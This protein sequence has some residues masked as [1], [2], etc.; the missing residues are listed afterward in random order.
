MTSACPAYCKSPNFLKILAV[1][2]LIF[3]AAT[4]LSGG[5]VIFG[6]TEIQLAMGDTVSFVVWFNFVSGFAYVLA[7]IG[8]LRRAKWGAY[9]AIAVAVAIAL[10]FAAF[11]LH[12][13]NDGAFEP[14]T[15]A[16]MVLRTGVWMLIACVARKSLLRDSSAV[17]A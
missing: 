9:L 11:G 13:F 1:V 4:I 10:T 7:A 3:G 16:A 6:S 8:L 15:V 12:I 2:A 5:S 14:R 17:A